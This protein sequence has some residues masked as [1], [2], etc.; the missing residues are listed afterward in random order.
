MPSAAGSKPRTIGQGTT[1][2]L[3]L[4]LTTAVT[5][6]V[7][8]RVGDL[9]VGVPSNLVETGATARAKSE[10]E[11]AYNR[12]TTMFSGEQVPFYWS[13]ALLQARQRSSEPG[14]TQHGGHRP[15]R[16]AAG[17]PARRRSSGQPGSRGEEPGSAAVSACQA[18]RA[19]RC[20]PR[21]L[22]RYLQPGGADHGAWRAGTSAAGRRSRRGAGRQAGRHGCRAA[23]RRPQPKYHWCWWSTIRSPCAA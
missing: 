21:A 8:I 6:V 7:M 2:K 4:P 16:S 11:T 14:K 20:W 5:Q 1:F 22:W 17:C 3:V 9:S 19:S 13:G 10:V 15:K 23:C 12:G 18:W